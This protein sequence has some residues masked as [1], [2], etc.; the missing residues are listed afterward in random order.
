MDDAF[1][2]AEIPAVDA[3]STSF[4]PIPAG[5]YLA[6]LV[7][8]NKEDKQ[9]RDGGEIRE[10]VMKFA[11]LDEDYKNRFIWQRYSTIHPS[12]KA[13]N[14]ARNMIGSFGKAVGVETVRNPADLMEKPVGLKI[15]IDPQREWN[16][17][18]YPPRNQVAGFVAA[19]N[20][21]AAPAPKAAGPAP[22]AKGPAPQ[23]AANPE[24]TEKKKMPWE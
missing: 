7:E 9:H 1:F 5:D 4:E 16:G 15:K 11:I 24:S 18:V 6:M 12:D 21:G 19:D 17:N 20:V 10:I 13:Q 2:G 14:F 22:Q 3:P 8:L 23:T